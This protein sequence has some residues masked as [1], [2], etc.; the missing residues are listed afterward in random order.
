[1]LLL[2]SAYYVTLDPLTGSI[3]S[4]VLTLFYFQAS[5][6]V[7]AEKEEGKAVKG[8]KKGK[9]K[10]GGMSWGWFAF[11]VHLLGWV[12]QIGPG[13]GYFEGVK[14]AL[15]DSLGQALGVAPFFAFL[16]GIWAA[17][18]KGDLKIE[19]GDLV[20]VNRRIMCEGG[21]GYPWC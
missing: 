4:T 15:L 8:N 16:E 10:K 6:A 9:K 12:M 20:A 18:I 17:G 7:E 21:G 2:Y 19:V 5:G 11:W 3:F 1:M 14:P 13:H